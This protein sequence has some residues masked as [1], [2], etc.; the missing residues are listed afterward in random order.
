MDCVGPGEFQNRRQMLHFDQ[1]TLQVPPPMAGPPHSV[2]DSETM[3]KQSVTV[4]LL[5]VPSVLDRQTPPYCHLSEID[6][7]PLGWWM[8]DDL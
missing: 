4:S 3:A 5:P 8:R 2:K 7:C 6:E 1:G